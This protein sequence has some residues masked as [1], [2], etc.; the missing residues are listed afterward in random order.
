MDNDFEFREFGKIARL[1]RECVVTEKID[2]TNAQIYIVRS[3]DGPR[4]NVVAYK[5]LGIS[6]GLQMFAGS[7]TRWITPEDDNHGFAKWAKSHA[8]EL[9]E[10]GE[11]RHFGEWWGGGIQR[12]Y[13]F[14]KGE[15]FFSLFNT[16][17]WV[18]ADV[19]P[20]EK[21]E[22][23][24]ACCNIV[25]VLYRGLFDTMAVASALNLLVCHGSYAAPG[26][27]RPEGVVIYHVAGNFYWKKTIEK[28]DESKSK[29]KISV[30]KPSQL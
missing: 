20:G 15:K 9:F 3:L 16:G 11:G 24:P 6:G 8:E 27:M 10:L 17:R 18:P 25:P 4:P 12:G 1:A 2:G 19:T 21:Q 22:H 7:R 23:P 14:K 29:S 28:D 5:D 26:F 13:G 30:D